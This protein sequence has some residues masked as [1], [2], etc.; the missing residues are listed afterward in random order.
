VRA[1][2]PSRKRVDLYYWA[3]IPGRGEF[4]R[5][6]LEEGGAAWTDVVRRKG[7]KGL[8]DMLRIM[9]GRKRGA[10][11]F[12]PPFV[13]AGGAIVSQTANVLAYLAPRL[14][15]VPADAALRAEALQ[16]QLTIADFVGEI[17][18]THHPIGGGLYYRDQKREAKR[19][20]R[21]FVRERLPKYLDWLER[22]L[23]RN[24]K[25]RSRWLVGA[26]LTYADLSAFQVVDGLRY[27]FPNAMARHE[28]EIPLLVALRDR[29][30]AR[31]RIAAYLAS[32]RRLPFNQMGI[33]R[34][35]PALDAPAPRS[36]R[37]TRT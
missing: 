23:A 7:R 36:R 4:I 29:V 33:F 6:A 25:S 3:E 37:R 10:L 12:A 15:L 18:D 11:P 13:R 24:R 22:I 16:I 17:H 8:G 27:A 1:R 20:S 21:G 31:P 28:P 30:A 35:Y 34:H 9:G 2:A 14:G 32:E 19:R 5:L 26:D